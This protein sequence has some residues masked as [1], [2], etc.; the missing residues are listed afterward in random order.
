MEH[1]INSWVNGHHESKLREMLYW[2]SAVNKY[3]LSP[4]D[5]EQIVTSFIARKVVR[6]EKNMQVIF[7]DLF[8][9]PHNLWI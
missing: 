5:N 8:N 4:N 9:N 3:S 2:N 6:E 7:I 1:K